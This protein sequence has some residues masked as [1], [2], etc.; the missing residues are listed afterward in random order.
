MRETASV[1][2]SLPYASKAPFCIHTESNFVLDRSPKDVRLKW[3]YC[4]LI[5]VL[6]F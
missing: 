2:V 4:L 3:P 5:R 1:V 6:L